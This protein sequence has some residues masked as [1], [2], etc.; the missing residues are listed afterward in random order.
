MGINIWVGTLSLEQASMDADQREQNQRFQDQ[1]ALINQVLRAA[2]LP[3]H[4]EPRFGDPS[5]IFSR[6]FKSALLPF[7][8]FVEKAENTLGLEFPHA[9]ISGF[10]LAHQLVV[11]LPVIFEQVFFPAP[12]GT[13][14]V[15]ALG[16][17]Y[18]L[19]R[20]CRL[21]ARILDIYSDIEPDLAAERDPVRDHLQAKS[22][23][24]QQEFMHAWSLL[25]LDHQ[26]DTWPPE[27][28]GCWKLY[29]AAKMS[30][31]HGAA[32]CMT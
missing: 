27:A 25:R 7:C 30:V 2:G 8:D 3:E 16:S 1:F 12:E 20:E 13:C 17:A 23:V 21:L 26:D 22:G 14:E 15:V 28:D 24:E 9:R 32:V 11:Y 29:E 10:A 5:A 18:A 19:C 31:M 6:S 4:H